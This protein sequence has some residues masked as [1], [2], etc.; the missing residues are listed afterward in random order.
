M[1][2]AF[3]HFNSFSTTAA[4]RRETEFI[5]YSGPP[6][7]GF[8]NG[9]VREVSW[10]SAFHFFCIRNTPKCWKLTTVYYLENR[11]VDR[12][13]KIGALFVLHMVHIH[14]RHILGLISL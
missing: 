2:R 13:T 14:R 7:S 8:C 3:T 4:K 5:S 10:L 9:V 6:V 12:L 11:K 1:V